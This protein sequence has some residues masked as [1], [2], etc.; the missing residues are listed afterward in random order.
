MLTVRHIW[1]T[2]ENRPLLNGVS[3]QVSAGETVCLL[4]SSGS[5]KSTLLRIIAG[6]EQPERGQVL[7]DGFDLADTPVHLRRFG[8]M[9]QDYALFP[10][11]NVEQNVA[12]GLRMLN[13]PK[14]EIK[15]RV[16]EA[17]KQVNLETFARRRVTDLS[18]G[19]QQR[20]AL[21]RALAPR[22]RLLMLDEPL[23]ALDH[24]LRE[25]LVG[26]LRNLLHTTG[27]PAIYVT[28]DQEEAFVVADRLILLHHG[29]IEQEGEPA[30][31]YRRPVST[32]VARFLGMRNLFQGEVISRSPLRVRISLG[33]LEGQ[34][35]E[36]LDPQVGSKVTVLIRPAG[37]DS[38]SIAGYP[39]R[40]R[41]TV[42]DV[43]FRG[44]HYRVRL[45]CEGGES[46]DFTLAD[47]PRTGSPLTIGFGC[48][49]VQC[50]VDRNGEEMIGEEDR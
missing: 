32:W 22:P 4:G 23:G 33:V 35:C 37:I 27:I 15:Q 11:R 21:A 7:W 31:I 14:A 45:R 42:E 36:Q 34:C 12:F 10:H 44:E 46:L 47:P 17:L 30:E 3:F 8:L 28:H 25:Q 29:K 16:M 40:V 38:S 50:L 6:L 1:K 2:Y 48:E 20:V 24:S 5:G 19:E 26:E 13:L 43:V 18:G 41:G 9:F 49:A 39:H